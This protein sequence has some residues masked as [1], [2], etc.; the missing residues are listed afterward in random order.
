MF[1]LPEEAEK[2]PHESGQVAQGSRG[3]TLTP[4][5]QGHTVKPKGQFKETHIPPSRLEGWDDG[6]MDQ[7]HQVHETHQAA[8][9]SMSSLSI[10]EF[11]QKFLTLQILFGNVKKIFF[12]IK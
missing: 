10:C 4:G 9:N 6:Q 3:S 12:I 8:N 2:T 11:K 1:P 7:V 5:H